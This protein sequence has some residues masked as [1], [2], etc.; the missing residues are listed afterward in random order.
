MVDKYLTVVLSDRIGRPSDTFRSKGVAGFR[1]VEFGFVNALCTYAKMLNRKA[2]LPP[3]RFLLEARHNNDKCVSENFT[4]NKYL[5]LSRY[6]NIEH[7]PPFDFLENTDIST[8]KE[9][10]Y[11]PSNTSFYDIDNS[12]DIVALLNYQD[13]S[14]YLQMCSHLPY[15]RQIRN[16]CSNFILSFAKRIISELKLNPFIFIHL[17]RGDMELQ[18]NDYT[19]SAFVSEIINSNIKKNSCIVIATNEK[20]VKYKNDLR[21]NLTEYTLYFEEDFREYL[22]DEVLNDNFCMYLILDVIA[23][24]SRLNIGTSG[25]CRLGNRCNYL[26]DN[27]YSRR[28]MRKR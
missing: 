28:K 9:L 11:Y 20:S 24:L 21:E 8:N 3:P 17:R 1:H 4:W 2:V 14:R 16:P 6:K 25:Y 7:Q 23:R 13:E 26:L 27:I 15:T 19:N 10:K 12:V 5:N 18:T 22:P